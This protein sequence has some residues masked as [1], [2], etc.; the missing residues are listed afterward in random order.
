MRATPRGERVWFDPIG[1]AIQPGDTVRWIVSADVHTTSAY[2]PSND[3]HSLRI[4]AGARP[5]D[6][7]FLVQPG[8]HFDVTLTVPGVYDYRASRRS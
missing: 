5:W 2:H 8:T 3:H 1:L 7:G 4:P 6:S